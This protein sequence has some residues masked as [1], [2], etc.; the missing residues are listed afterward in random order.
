MAG[1]LVGLV[2]QGAVTLTLVLTGLSR[3]VHR[4]A[5]R[6]LERP[7]AINHLVV[8]AG[9]CFWLTLGIGTR[10]TGTC[11]GLWCRLVMRLRRVR[12]L[13]YPVTLAV[14]PARTCTLK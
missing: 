10:I 5:P 8:L 6:W 1:S 2:R 13:G 7:W 3:L 11:R 4:C 12:L 14:Q 9:M